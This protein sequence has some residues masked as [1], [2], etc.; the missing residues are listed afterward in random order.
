[1]NLRPII[2]Y[3]RGG[4][5]FGFVTITFTWS[6]LRLCSFL[7][8]PLDWQSIFYSTA[9]VL[10]WRRPIPPYV[11]WRSFSPVYLKTIWSPKFS[12]PNHR[13]TLMAGFQSW[14][15][16]EL[17]FILLRISMERGRGGEGRGGGVVCLD[18][19]TKSYRDIRSSC[20][21]QELHRLSR[22]CE[23]KI[24]KPSSVTM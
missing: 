1:M 9:F 7:T 17:F 14:T 10:F 18:Y 3:R 15:N 5:N 16:Y 6:P 23:N 12:D 19:T 4:G 24:T 8:I 22:P 11:S 13:Q 2:I 21:F 20:P